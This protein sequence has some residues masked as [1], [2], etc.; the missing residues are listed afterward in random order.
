M[1]P[2]SEN[3]GFSLVFVGFLEV[4]RGGAG[5]VAPGRHQGGTREAP[6]RQCD[7]GWS[8]L[9]SNYVTTFEERSSEDLTRPANSVGVPSSS[10]PTH[11]WVLLQTVSLVSPCTSSTFKGS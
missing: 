2:K 3:V 9:R 4:V 6:G 10:P 11:Q 5:K 8:S 1:G 7:S